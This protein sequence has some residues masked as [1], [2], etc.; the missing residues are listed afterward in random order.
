MYC[1]VILKK[2]PQKDPILYVLKNVIYSEYAKNIFQNRI[3]GLKLF[4]KGFWNIIGAVGWGVIVILNIFEKFSTF[5]TKF[6]KVW[7]NSRIFI[8]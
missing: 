7:Q 4:I 8:Y 2:F 6:H 5:A 1:S 3:S